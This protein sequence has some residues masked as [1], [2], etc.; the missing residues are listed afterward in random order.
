M[1][2]FIGEILALLGSIGTIVIN[3]ISF[4][5]FIFLLVNHELTSL[6]SAA[7]LNE[8]IVVLLTI[9]GIIHG[10]LYSCYSLRI[11]SLGRTLRRCFYISIIYFGIILFRYIFTEVVLKDVI[12]IDSVFTTLFI[13]GVIFYSLQALGFILNYKKIK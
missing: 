2:N 1:K 13:I 12:I 10:I 5:F 8:W 9:I 3:L 4:G 11:I 7:N 6:I